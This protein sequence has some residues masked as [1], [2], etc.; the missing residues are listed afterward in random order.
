MR[1]QSYVCG[2]SLNSLQPIDCEL[3]EGVR[4]PPIQLQTGQVHA[5]PGSKHV[6]IKWVEPEER[7]EGVAGPE[8]TSR[9]LD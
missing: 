9:R 4:E 2:R 6:V 8:G 5:V 7:E 1:G 3:P